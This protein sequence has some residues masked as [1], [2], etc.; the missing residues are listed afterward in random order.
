MKKLDAAIAKKIAPSAL[1]VLIAGPIFLFFV[2]DLIMFA[3]ISGTHKPTA[4][5]Q[6]ADLSMEIVMCIFTGLL[7]AFGARTI[8]RALKDD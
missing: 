2:M 7:T 5:T 6:V 1:M 8:W 3:A 4:A